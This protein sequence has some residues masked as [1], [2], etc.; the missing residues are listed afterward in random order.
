MMNKKFIASLMLALSLS[1]LGATIV[2]NFN[3]SKDNS[4]ASLISPCAE[5]PAQWLD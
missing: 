2:N 4:V 1:L 5:H 3:I